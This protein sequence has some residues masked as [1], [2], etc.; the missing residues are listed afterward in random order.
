MSPSLS[1]LP[2]GFFF[3]FFFLWKRRTDVCKHMLRMFETVFGWVG[4]L[5]GGGIKNL[6]EVGLLTKSNKCLMGYK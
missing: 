1:S 3:F 5:G 6:K 4:G 2:K